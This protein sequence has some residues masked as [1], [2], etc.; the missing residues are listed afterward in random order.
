MIDG[1]KHVIW[2]WNGTLFND[3]DAALVSLNTMLGERGLTILDRLGYRRMFGFP[4]IDCY[5]GLGF[6]FSTD[7]EWDAIANEFHAHYDRNAVSSELSAG[8][9]DVLAQISG[10]GVAMSVLSAAESGKLNRQLEQCGIAGYF[11][12]VFGH[13]DLYGSSKIELGRKL[14]AKLGCAP[15]EALLVGDTKHDYEVSAD[16]GCQCA[17]Y[18]EGHQDADRLGSCGCRLISSFAEFL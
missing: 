14:L 13:N 12:Y 7:A 16:L 17:L 10:A 2:D 15:E 5:R 3:V 11:P 6:E 18:L 8:V 1:I 9:P 4:V